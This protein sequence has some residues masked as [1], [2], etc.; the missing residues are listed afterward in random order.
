MMGKRRSPRRHTVHTRHSRY[1]IRNYGRGVEYT[2]ITTPRKIEPV[3]FHANY[4]E[5][6]PSL[7]T[8]FPMKTPLDFKFFPKDISLLMSTYVI[9]ESPYRPEYVERQVKDSEG[10]VRVIRVPEDAGRSSSREQAMFEKIFNVLKDDK[11]WKIPTHYAIVDDKTKAVLIARALKFYTGGA[12]IKYLT[13]GTFMVGSKGYY[14][15]IGA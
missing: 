11:N 10:K 15:Y 6:N 8:K 1:N 2:T 12:E 3:L 5:W 9:F 7:K 13:D 4:R 14:E